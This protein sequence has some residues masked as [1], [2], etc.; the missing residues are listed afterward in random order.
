M[1][2]GYAHFYRPPRGL[3]WPRPE[4]RK[5]HVSR[6]AE[7]MKCAQFQSMHCGSK[8]RNTP[9]TT[10]RA[11]MMMEAGYL[12]QGDGGPPAALA[13]GSAPGESGVSVLSVRFQG[14]AHFSATPQQHLIWFQISPQAR[15][16]CRIADQSLRHTQPSGSLAI[17]P[18][19]V[20]S[21]A[22]TGESVDALLV[23]I[24]PARLA[25]AAAEDSALA[26]QVLERFS[27]HDQALL[28]LGRTLALET[29][30][31]YPKGPL[32]WNELASTFINGLIARHTSE[33]ENRKR[34]MLGQELLEKLKDYILAHLEE[35]IEVATLANM[36]GRSPFHFFRIFTRSVGLTP[37]RYIVHLRLQRATELVRE[38]RSGLAEIATVTGFADQ[39]H[40]S[41]WARRVH[42]VPLTS[43]LPDYQ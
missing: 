8:S 30:H 22:D 10:A 17:C 6:L 35:P 36:A 16:A 40:L 15:F 31:N 23:T 39:S 38:G 43:L 1:A 29:A 7:S 13:A 12:V 27:G 37:H 32:F 21:V 25:L 26:A 3:A 41:R 24:D 33:P 28:E 42:G 4:A 5:R 11:N 18:A 19:G 9:A 14:G 2:A 20:D 34:G